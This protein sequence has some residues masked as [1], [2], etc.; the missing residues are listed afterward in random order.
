[1]KRAFFSI[2]FVAFAVA[3]TAQVQTPAPSPSCKM[4]QMVGLTKVSVDYSRPGV[5]ERKIFGSLVPMNEYWRTGANQST[6]FT[7]DKD[8]MVAGQELKAGTYSLFTKP[9]AESWE[10]IFYSDLSRNTPPAEWDEAAIAAKA[11]VRPVTN[12]MSVETFT[13]DIN[14][15]RDDK[16]IIHVKWDNVIVPIPLE[17][18]TD[19][20]VISS[21]DA[22]M[23]GPSANEY[24]NAANYYAKTGR[25]MNKALEWINKSLELNPGR[26]WVLRDKSN[27]QAKLGDFA[28]AIA[29]AK[30]SMAAAQEAGNMQYV[31][32][33][34]DAIAEWTN[35]KK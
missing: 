32:F 24:R 12:S 34:Q 13:I 14:D 30:E 20:Q 19:K 9:G 22:A 17:V 8:V 4:E 18:G 23:A 27:I 21:I 31:K 7:F 11:N 5:K 29:T 33:N 28:G 25:D 35:M 16:A 1:M 2:L 15:I 3:M 6:K 10:I 26:F